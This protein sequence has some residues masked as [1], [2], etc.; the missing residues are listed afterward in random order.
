MKVP[1]IFS[2]CLFHDFIGLVSCHSRPAGAAFEGTCGLGVTTVGAGQCHVPFFLLHVEPET[3]NCEGN[4]FQGDST[5]DSGALMCVSECVRVSTR[6][7]VLRNMSSSPS[8]QCRSWRE[9]TECGWCGTGLQPWG[10]CLPPDDGTAR[11]VLSS[12]NLV[13]GRGGRA[14]SAAAL[15]LRWSSPPG[16]LPLASAF[17]CF[18]VVVSAS[19]MNIDF[20]TFRAKSLARN[21][22]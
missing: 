5:A 10:R 8:S 4:T 21:L 11:P 3:S 1:G 16:A 7:C 13:P 6:A 2:C 15:S 14:A 12:G 18:A 19:C 9:H 22:H 20:F 17:G